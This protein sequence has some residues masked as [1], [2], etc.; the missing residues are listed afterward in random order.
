VTNTDSIYDLVV[1]GAGPGGYV[2]AIRAAQLGLKVACVESFKKLGGTCLN[3]GCIPSKA[4]LDSSE[5]FAELAHFEEHGIKV[6]TPKLELKKMMERKDKVVDRLTGGIEMLFRKQKITRVEGRGKLVKG[7]TT[8]KVEVELAGQKQILETKAVVLA[9]GSVPST[10]PFL[11]IDEKQ[12]LTST[13]ALAL[14]EV[15]SHLLVVGGGFIG[16]EMGSVW[17]RLGAKVTVIE[18]LD[19]LLPAMDQELVRDFKKALESQ[20]ISFKLGYKCTALDQKKNKL[21]LSLEPAKG[22]EKETIEGS[23]VLVAVG[24]SP[25]SE[26]LGLE[27]AGVVKDQRGF[28]VVG[29]NFE[30]NVKNVFAIGDL[31]GGAML[32]HKAEEEGVIVAEGL[33]N[34]KLHIDYALIPGVIYTDPEIA[35]IGFTEEELKTKNVPYKKGVFPY[36]GNGRAIAMGKMNGKVKILAHAV[37]HK[38]L[39]MHILG[40]HASSLIGEGVSAMSRRSTLEEV[41]HACHPHPTLTEAVKEAALS[42]L[43]RPIHI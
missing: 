20:N 38:I 23:H 43:G 8:H 5:K 7:G 29:D 24:R 42:A 30:T 25:F 11:P 28:V 33:G 37:T 31:I 10:I 22:G 13:G 34:K 3:I 41:G 26:G 40:A 1:V 16:L 19:T 2:C 4:L 6:G 39:G 21:T 17:A 9:T 15:P 32:A 35:A 36:L 14:E 27:E 12:I 18:F